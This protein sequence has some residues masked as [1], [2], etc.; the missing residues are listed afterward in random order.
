MI[1]VV[2]GLP[3]Y[4]DYCFKKTKKSKTFWRKKIQN[5][6]KKVPCS[7][8]TSLHSAIQRDA[9]RSSHVDETMAPFPKQYPLWAVYTTILFRLSDDTTISACGYTDAEPQFKTTIKFYILNLRVNEII[10]DSTK[11]NQI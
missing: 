2:L 5:I 9:L 10:I 4:Y 8:G 1:M 11:N 6:T 3:I 7:S